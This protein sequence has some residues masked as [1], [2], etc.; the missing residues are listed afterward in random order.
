MSGSG[1]AFKELPDPAAAPEKVWKGNRLS[2]AGLSHA[3]PHLS[4]PRLW[5]KSVYESE[6]E[7]ARWPRSRKGAVGTR[8]HAL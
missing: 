2:K 8:L 3:L 4:L 5:E 6:G 1:N 7:R